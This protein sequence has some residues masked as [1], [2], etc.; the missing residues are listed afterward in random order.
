M[1]NDTVATTVDS[2]VPV[3]V[4]GNGLSNAINVTAGDFTSCALL[5]GGSLRCWG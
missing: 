1:T 2:A 3:L 4:G 5:D